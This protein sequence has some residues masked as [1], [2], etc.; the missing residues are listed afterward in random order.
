KDILDPDRFWN[1]ELLQVNRVGF[2]VKTLES[3]QEGQ[4]DPR[5]KGLICNHAYSVLKAVEV[6]GKRFV[7]IRCVWS[8]G[9]DVGVFACRGI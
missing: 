3:E 7:F 6:N 4:G 5:H 9:A 2:S 8:G 1:D